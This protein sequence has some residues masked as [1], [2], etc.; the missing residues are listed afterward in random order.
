[1]FKSISTC[2]A[3]A[4][5]TGL[6]AADPQTVA[7][8]AM[9]KP[10]TSFGYLDANKDERLTRDEAKADWAV[11]EGFGQV[12]AN[13]DGYLDKEE[14]ERLSRGAEPRRVVSR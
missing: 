12:D 13:G 10:V 9:L 1:M 3:L 14:F 5:A 4:T 2:L 11:I 8:K 7:S 6:L